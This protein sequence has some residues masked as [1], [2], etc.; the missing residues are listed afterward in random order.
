MNKKYT[1]TLALAVL[2]SS[3][4][5]AQTVSPYISEVFEYVPAP[6][7]F[8]NTVTS[9]YTD[10]D[11][12][13]DVLQKAKNKLIGKKSSFLTLGGFGGYI[14][15][16]FD[17][18]IQNVK[19]E[20]DFKIYGNAGQ[21]SSEPGI[22]MIAYDENGNGIPDD[23]WYELAGS[24]YANSVKDYKI[25]YYRPTPADGDVKWEDNKGA[26][27]YIH[28]NNYHK[29]ASYYPLWISENTLT[30][31]GTKI[32]GNAVNIGT[33]T[34][35]NWEL[36]PFAWG[37]ADN[38][39]NNSDLS[40]FKIEWAVDKNGN[41]VEL[42]GID[43]IKIYSATVQEAGWMGET[44]TEVAGI[45]DLHPGFTNIESGETTDQ[46]TVYPNP[47]CDELFIAAQADGRARIFSIVGTCL[48]NLP[49]IEGNNT[50]PAGNLPEGQYTLLIETPLGNTVFKIIK[51]Q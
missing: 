3:S 4:I 13:N 51:Q 36:R 45:E 49:L 40:N 24:E 34:A 17:H 11:T 8:I 46:V 7:Q 2:L 20:Y 18:T 38:Q 19:G 15:V 37:Y 31:E 27:G 14:V 28:R 12:G 43:F 33:E 47:F 25:T 1:A 26:S 21:T 9:C 41:P 22:V 48:I 32:P 44:S 39:P 50:I 23:T 29:Q 42:K 35:Q 6:G 30:F 5:A 10:G 16:G